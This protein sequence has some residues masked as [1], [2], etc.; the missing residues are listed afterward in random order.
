[1]IRAAFE[2]I[3]WA[4]FPIRA[5]GTWCGPGGSAAPIVRT[6]RR[7]RSRARTDDQ[8]GAVRARQWFDGGTLGHAPPI[9]R[10]RAPATSVVAT[11]IRASPAWI[12]D[13]GNP[14][15]SPLRAFDAGG[16]CRLLVFSR[17]VHGPQ[18]RVSGCP[19]HRW[20]PASPFV[21]TRRQTFERVG[22]VGRRCR[23]RVANHG[24]KAHAWR[25]CADTDVAVAR[26]CYVAAP[27]S[28][29]D[30]V[31]VTTRDTIAIVV[32]LPDLQI[33][34]RNLGGQRRSWWAG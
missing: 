13:T 3:R 4:Y 20:V 27:W 26:R 31:N 25:V 18:F 33:R 1:M 29:P 16:W 19:N 2:H 15:V 10:G 9:S 5:A 11:T 34:D 8:V 14:A 32:A 21:V 22:S 28:L 24:G 23:Q 12:D 7:T 6:C 30:P 17:R